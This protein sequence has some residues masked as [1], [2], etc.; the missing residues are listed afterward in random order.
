V[1]PAPPPVTPLTEGARIL[2]LY[3]VGNYAGVTR[4][5]V[6][7][8]TEHN[9]TFQGSLLG[10]MPSALYAVIVSGLV[11]NDKEMVRQALCVGQKAIRE[12]ENLADIDCFGHLVQYHCPPLHQIN[13]CRQIRG[14]TKDKCCPIGYDVMT[15]RTRYCL[16]RL[17]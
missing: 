2:S 15:K 6:A 4:A 3:D 14:E 5:F 11:G 16:D 9:A 12:E 7:A 8:R 10:D 1:E 13:D 17:F